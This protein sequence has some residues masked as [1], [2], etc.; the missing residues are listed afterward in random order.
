MGLF[1]EAY[2]GSVNTSHTVAPKTNA[3]HLRL[4]WGSAGLS[5]GIFFPRVI[6]GWVEGIAKCP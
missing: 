6:V 4:G 5:L 2:N 1:W 3:V